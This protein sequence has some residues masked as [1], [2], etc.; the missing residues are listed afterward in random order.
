VNTEKDVSNP[1][2]WPGVP[3]WLAARRERRRAE[4]FQQ[5]EKAAEQTRR[6]TAAMHRKVEI[7]AQYGLIA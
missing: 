7:C 2:N 6:S 5:R 1:A 3:T 4:Y